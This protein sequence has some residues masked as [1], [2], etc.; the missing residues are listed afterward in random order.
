MNPRELKG[1]ARN[2]FEMNGHRKLKV[3]SDFNEMSYVYLRKKDRE[4]TSM[5]KTVLKR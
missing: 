2:K 5:T 3:K 1:Q 4:F